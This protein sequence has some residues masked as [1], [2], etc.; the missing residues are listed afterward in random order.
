MSCNALDVRSVGPPQLIDDFVLLYE[1]GFVLINPC[2]Q[3]VTPFQRV[4][5]RGSFPY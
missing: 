5:T 2:P 3:K 1:Y 4:S